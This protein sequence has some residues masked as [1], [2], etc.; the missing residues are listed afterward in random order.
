M[1]DR[2]AQRPADLER[3][4]EPRIEPLRGDADLLTGEPERGVAQQGAR[5]EMGLGEDL[6]AVA[7]AEDQPTVVRERASRRA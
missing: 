1:G 5:H 6:E 2:H 3:V 7:D 4:R